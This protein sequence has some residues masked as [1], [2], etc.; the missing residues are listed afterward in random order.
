MFSPPACC[1]N[2][3]FVNVRLFAITT[4]G[5]KATLSSDALILDVAIC[6]EKPDI[7]TSSE[8]AAS[9]NLTVVVPAGP[10]VKSYNV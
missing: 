6:P 4:L 2:E 5:V 9:V 1:V 3:P 10:V 8:P 7:V